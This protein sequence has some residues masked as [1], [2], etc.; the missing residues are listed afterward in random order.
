MYTPDNKNKNISVTKM[1][2][3]LCTFDDLPWGSA[4]T[5]H[6]SK[7]NCWS[8]NKEVDLSY[9]S[10]VYVLL[11]SIWHYFLAYFNASCSDESNFDVKCSK[12][13]FNAEPQ[14]GDNLKYQKMN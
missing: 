5:N 8:L 13:N 12:S 9:G 11:G 1:H 6:S 4:E 14:I 10:H 3:F 2:R 7:A